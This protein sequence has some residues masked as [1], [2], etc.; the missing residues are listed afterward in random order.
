MTTLASTRVVVLELVVN[1]QIARI[2]SI[3]SL[4]FRRNGAGCHRTQSFRFLEA[5]YY[6][7]AWLEVDNDRGTGIPSAVPVLANMHE[8]SFFV[9]PEDFRPWTLETGEWEI[10][11]FG[12]PLFCILTVCCFASSDMRKQASKQA[13]QHDRQRSLASMSLSRPAI[14]TCMNRN[15]EHYLDENDSS[16]HRLQ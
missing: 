10:G 13:V 8:P 15:G 7:S 16:D 5:V 14:L 2:V 11:T 1:G 3:G 12:E 9:K 6:R 4:Q